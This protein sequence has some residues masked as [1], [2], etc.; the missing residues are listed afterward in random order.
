MNKA[1]VKKELQAMLEVE[2]K[3]LYG[4]ASGEGTEKEQIY[5]TSK[6]FE[7]AEYIIALKQHLETIRR[8]E[9]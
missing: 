2:S 6:L 3:I 9:D 5:L 1:I 7:V 8:N 4:L